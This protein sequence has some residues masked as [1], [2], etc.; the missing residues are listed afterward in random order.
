MDLQVYFR[1]I[2]ATEESLQDA[3]PLLVSLETQDGGREGVRTEVPRRIAARMIVEG[4]ARLATADEAR[5]FQEQ[6]AEAK[7]QA[8]QLAAAS[9][10]QFTVIS[11]NEMR[12]LKGGAQP[13]KE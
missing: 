2:R 10:M 8:D 13:G 4:A 7:R 5:D 6:K 12:K 11:P 3:S 1:K 9:R